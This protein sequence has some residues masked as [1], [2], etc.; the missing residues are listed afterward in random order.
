MF[1]KKTAVG[2]F[3]IVS[4]SQKTKHHGSSIV[5]GG[6]HRFKHHRVETD[7]A[8]LCQKFYYRSLVLNDT[9]GHSGRIFSET[10]RKK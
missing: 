5:V 4:S 8:A 3:D 1:I 6:L 10:A 7:S 9:E 2:R